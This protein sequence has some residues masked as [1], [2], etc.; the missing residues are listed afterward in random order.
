MDFD[1]QRKWFEKWLLKQFKNTPRV[2]L[3]QQ[4]EAYADETINTM[5]IAFCAG[6]EFREIEGL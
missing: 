2:M 5:F 3:S 4:G 1:Q 6:W